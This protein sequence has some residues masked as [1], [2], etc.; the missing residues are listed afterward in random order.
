MD[1]GNAIRTVP[2]SEVFHDV[3]LFTIGLLS[4]L[5]NNQLQGKKDLFGKF[6]IAFCLTLV[7]MHLP[8]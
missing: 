5:V 7:S 2:L 3:R 1:G 4:V 6:F 8:Y